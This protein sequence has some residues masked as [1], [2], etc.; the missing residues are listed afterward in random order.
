MELKPALDVFKN[1]LADDLSGSVEAV[2]APRSHVEG[3]TLREINL[4]DRYQVTPIAMYSQ[5]EVYRADLGDI[6]LTAG[7]SVLLF[8]DW[9][10]LQL[11]A[12]ERNFLFITPIEKEPMRPQKAIFAGFWLAVALVMVIVF[13]LQLSMCLMTGALGM[14]LTRVITID[15]AYE[16]VDWRTI[17]L[18]AGL[19]P[20]G[21]ATEKKNGHGRMDRHRGPER[22]WRRK[23]HCAADRHWD[24][25]HD[26][27]PWSYPTWGPRWLLVPLVVNMAIAANADPRMAA[28]VV[29]L[30]TSNSFILPTH[31]V[32][33]LYMGAWA[34]SQQGLYEGG[35]RGI[36]GFHCC[37]DC[38]DLLFLRRL[39]QIRRQPWQVLSFLRTLL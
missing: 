11:L 14:I 39:I 33:A 29:G 17:F 23:P 37:D 10:R 22:H 19:I 30:A 1:Q 25:V 13:H 24:I 12:E 4:R 9:K 6:T 36:R 5:G 3:K 34:L 16:A 21:I 32:N 35:I 38:Y 18:L 20:L 7:D 8:G 31:Q 26:F 2:V 28:L 15:E 27:H